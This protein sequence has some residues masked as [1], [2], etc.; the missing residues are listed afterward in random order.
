MMPRKM[1]HC[2][3]CG[4]PIGEYSDYNPLDTCDKIECEYAA[5]EQAT[6]DN[7]IERE[8]AC[9]RAEGPRPL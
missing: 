6:Y 5:L 8:E 4:E 7:D 1:R 3:N 9:L 2:F